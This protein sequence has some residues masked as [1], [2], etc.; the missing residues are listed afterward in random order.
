MADISPNLHKITH[1]YSYTD[2]DH[3]DAVRS[4]AARV[5]A[6]VTG[7]HTR[8]YEMHTGEGGW[9]QKVTNTEVRG[10]DTLKYALES[11]CPWV[12]GRG[13]P[14]PWQTSVHQVPSSVTTSV[15]ADEDP[16]LPLDNLSADAPGATKPQCAL[17]GGRPL[18]VRAAAT[19][20]RVH[21][22]DVPR[23]RQQ[24]QGWVCRWHGCSAGSG[25]QASAGSSSKGGCTC[26][27]GA[28][29]CS[30]SLLLQYLA[31]HLST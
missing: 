31:Y 5:G 14:P 16:G 24:Q 11:C 3:R 25:Q 6:C 23:G 29:F 15:H 8:E 28:V 21:V 19:G 18:G 12:C 17:K 27:A 2:H 1:V 26:G 4:A 9:P 7:L 30:Y 22:K 20:V 13:L 10:Y